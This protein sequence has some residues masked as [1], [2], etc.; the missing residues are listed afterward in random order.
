M[1]EWVSSGMF[2]HWPAGHTLKMPGA[3]SQTLCAPNDRSREGSC[4]G[5]LTK[6]ITY[7]TAGFPCGD[8]AQSSEEICIALASF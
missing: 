3:K 6:Q 4:V 1:R 5:I 2:P 8:P 7:S